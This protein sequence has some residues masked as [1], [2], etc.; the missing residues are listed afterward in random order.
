MCV[1]VFFKKT[2][3]RFHIRQRIV[4]SYPQDYSAGSENILPFL[5]S[6]GSCEVPG[7]AAGCSIRYVYVCIG[8]RGGKG[9]HFSFHR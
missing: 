8:F 9:I 1:N 5:G 6:F 2:H 4:R 3:L 7:W